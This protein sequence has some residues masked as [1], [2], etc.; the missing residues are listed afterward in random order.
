MN[1]K[2]NACSHTP[3]D[4]ILTPGVDS[5]CERCRKPMGVMMDWEVI[6]H[7]IKGFG[8]ERM[9]KLRLCYEGSTQRF[10]GDHRVRVSA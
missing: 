4:H 7:R 5:R 10:P 6:V 3:H 1:V 8:M 2:G 9:A